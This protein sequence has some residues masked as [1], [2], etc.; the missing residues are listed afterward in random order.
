MCEQQACIRAASEDIVRA[1]LPRRQFKNG[2]DQLT[3]P[4]IA[5]AM[6]DQARMSQCDKATKEDHG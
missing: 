1:L 2:D 3:L 6:L 5:L 4:K